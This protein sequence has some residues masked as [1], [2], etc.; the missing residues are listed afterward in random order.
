MP[1]TY[2]DSTDHQ[3][4]QF[5][6]FTYWSMINV[7]VKYLICMSG[8]PSKSHPSLTLFSISPVLLLDK[9]LRLTNPLVEL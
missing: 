2:G 1:L 6:M 8:S 3:E 7:F 4:H 9:I 5:Y